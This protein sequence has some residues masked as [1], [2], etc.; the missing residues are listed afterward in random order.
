MAA[1]KEQ[2]LINQLA[3]EFDS[4]DGITTTFGFAQNPDTLSP[5]QLPAVVFVPVGFDSSPRAHHNVHRNEIEI[6]AV[7]FVTTRESMGGRLKFIENETMPFLFKVRNHFQLNAT[8]TTMLALG[9]LTQAS[10]FSGRYGV[11][12]TLLTY[13][14]VE[15]IGCIFR[16]RF[17]AV[18]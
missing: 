10:I 18:E 3:T 11:G 2:T 8:I 5:A 17:V 6:A 15:F 14:S 7:L 16:H 13:G 9:N 4:I 1:I 12:G